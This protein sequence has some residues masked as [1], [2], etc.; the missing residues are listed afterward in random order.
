MEQQALAAFR[1][2]TTLRGYSLPQSAIAEQ[3]I[4][5]SLNVTDFAIVVEWLEYWEGDGVQID[6]VIYQRVT[7]GADQT[8]GGAQ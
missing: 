7:R 6:G 8:E 5:K 2:I 1:K 4:L 3:R